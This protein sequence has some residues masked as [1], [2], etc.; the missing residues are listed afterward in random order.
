MNKR[1]RTKK[2]KKIVNKYGLEL[3]ELRDLIDS[4]CQEDL[5]NGAVSESLLEREKELEN[6]VFPALQIL[7][8]R[9]RR[10]KK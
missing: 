1:I 3:Y 5:D 2:A 9:V 8:K 4:Y 7:Y 6:L 10:V